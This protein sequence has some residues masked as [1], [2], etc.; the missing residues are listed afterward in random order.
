[1]DKKDCYTYKLWAWTYI[2]GDYR[3]WN[4]TIRR[5]N[6]LTEERK[7]QL[8][9]KFADDLAWKHNCNI[10]LYGCNLIE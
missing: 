6:E 3:E 10:A 7:E 4:K 9:G 8:S 1:M 5:K 2:N